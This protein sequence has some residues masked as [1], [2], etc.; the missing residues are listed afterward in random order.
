VSVQLR[1][2]PGD[3]NG[4][5]DVNVVDFSV[6]K[7]V[8]GAAG[9]N[10]AD[11]SLDGIVGGG[12]Y[13]VWRNNVGNTAMILGSAA[14]SEVP[15]PYSAWL[16]LMVGTIVVRRLRRASTANPCSAYSAACIQ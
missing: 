11:G 6:W 9:I 13:V 1:N 15:E 5:G 8:Y 10:P 4:D 2:L 12:D 14:T 16:L 3:Y 7:A